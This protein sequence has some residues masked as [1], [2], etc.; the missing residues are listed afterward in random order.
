MKR[1]KVVDSDSRGDSKNSIK[2]DK[3][4]IR[5]VKFCVRLR[6]ISKI[7]AEGMFNQ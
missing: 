4:K 6:S 1:P 5:Q 3:P 2:F 7:S